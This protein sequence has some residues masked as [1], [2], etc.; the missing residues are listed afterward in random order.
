MKDAAYA[1][2]RAHDG[3]TLNYRTLEMLTAAERRLGFTT[4]L[5]QGSYTAANPDSGSTHAGGGAL[6][7]RATGLSS[8]TR[9]RI[10]YRLRRIGFAAWLRTP[11]QGDWPYHIHAIAIGDREM[12]PAAR[13]Q[14]IDYRNGLN[15]LANKGPDDGPRVPWTVYPQELDMSFY[16]PEHW[17]RADWERFDQRAGWLKTITDGHGDPRDAKKI[18]EF[19]HKNGFE[20]EDVARQ[21][22]ESA[23]SAD[24]KLDQV[25]ELLRPPVASA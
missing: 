3:V 14:V 9:D 8:A 1:R 20:T 17:D 10:V 12:S 16:G 2:T 4:V 13:Q 23:A 18:L 24:A 25:L 11:A 21:T 7:V 19:I 5:T 22:Q 6:D 15:G